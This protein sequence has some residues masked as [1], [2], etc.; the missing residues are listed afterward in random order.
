MLADINKLPKKQKLI[1]AKEITQETSKYK[2]VVPH[3]ETFI[4]FAN[5]NYDED[6]L[7]SFI[8]KYGLLEFNLTIN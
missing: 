2:E 5:L 1:C 8:N 4:E 6:Q 7:I 3:E